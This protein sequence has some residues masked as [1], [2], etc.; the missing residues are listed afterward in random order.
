MGTVSS[1]ND[2][3]EKHQ[4]QAAMIYQ[5]FN[6]VSWPEYPIKSN[7]HLICVSPEFSENAAIFGLKSLTIQDKPI[8]VQTCQQAECVQA[9]D[10]LFISG[11]ATPNNIDLLDAAKNQAVLTIAEH[12]GEL[13]PQTMIA[14]YHELQHLHMNA[15]LSNLRQ[16]GLTISSRL[17]RLMR[18]IEAPKQTMESQ[19]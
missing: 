1:A 8:H 9:C 13:A 10:I 16:S 14:F 12:A 18:R 2:L 3:Q 11:D 19:P 6:F 17:L 7:T 4:L 5:M 15:Y